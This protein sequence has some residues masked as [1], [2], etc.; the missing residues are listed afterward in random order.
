MAVQCDQDDM[1]TAQTGSGAPPPC[2]YDGTVPD[3]AWHLGVDAT[4]GRGVGDVSGGVQTDGADCVVSVLQVRVL[5]LVPACPT[6]KFE[7]L[8]EF[9]MQVTSRGASLCVRV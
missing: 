5:Q 1:D 3:A 4:S 7:R 6:S 8:F 2:T 9:Y